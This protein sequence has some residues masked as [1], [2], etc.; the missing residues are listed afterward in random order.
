MIFDLDASSL[1]KLFVEE[2][3]S[4]TVRRWVADA[5]VVVT[6][7][8][9]FPEPLRC[10]CK[11]SVIAVTAAPRRFRQTVANEPVTRRSEPRFKF[12]MER[13]PD[14]SC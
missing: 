6:S 8:A 10:Q 12:Y 2:A 13:V 4:D 11:A 1:V 7:R 9:A 14:S 5:R 3:H